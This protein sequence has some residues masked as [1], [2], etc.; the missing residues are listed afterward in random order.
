MYLDFLFALKIQPKIVTPTF[1]FDYPVCQAAQA[2]IS[3]NDDGEKVANRF[4]LF[5]EGV[6]LANAYQE[7]RDSDELLTRFD[8]NNAI[9]RLHGKKEV[10][11]DYQLLD[12]LPLMPKCAGAS[13]GIDRLMKIISGSPDI[14]TVS[15]THLTLPT[16][17][18]V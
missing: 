17:R 3:G 12:S 16:K 10:S 7:L 11:V 1:V 15:Y 13:L 9:R 14:N 4:E 8:D 6:E 5:I 18:I 2:E